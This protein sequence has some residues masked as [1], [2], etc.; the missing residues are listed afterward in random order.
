MGNLV[1]Q[2]AL[3][4]TVTLVGPN[5]AATTSFTLPAADGTAGQPMVT[6]GSGTLSLA[7][8]G[9]AGGGTGLTSPGTA[10]FV[11]TSTGSAWTTA[12]PSGAI[13]AQTF[14]SSGTWTKP[15]GATFVQVEVWGAGGGGASGARRASG[16]GRAGGGGGKC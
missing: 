6:N 12:L 14:T 8:L 10:G 7:T 1:F 16:G 9:A 13:S 3:G 5:T 11:L 4:G 15:S 2:A